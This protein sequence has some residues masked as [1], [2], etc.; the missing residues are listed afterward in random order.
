MALIKCP[1]CG[2][3]ISDKATSCPNCGC[4]STDIEDAEKI[5]DTTQGILALF[6]CVLGL[7]MAFIINDGILLII[8]LI[9]FI[10]SAILG[11]KCNNKL[12]FIAVV[13]SGFGIALILIEF[14]TDM[15]I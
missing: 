12:F 4:P 7:I 9:M 8:P 5:N 11:I 13:I 10:I 14:I 3:E 6:L 15:L 2:K 1:E